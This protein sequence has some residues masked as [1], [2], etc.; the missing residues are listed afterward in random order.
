MN[1]AH[2]QGANYETFEKRRS[3]R[4]AAGSRSGYVSIVLSC[5]KARGFASRFFVLEF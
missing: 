2:N 3:N 1:A 4:E 5:E